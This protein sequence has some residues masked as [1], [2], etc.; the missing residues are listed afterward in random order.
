[1]DAHG[2]DLHSGQ[3][4]RRNRK[5]YLPTADRPHQPGT[6]EAVAHRDWAETG[7]C[8]LLTAAQ[9]ARLRLTPD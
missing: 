1:M 7:R 2:F 5:A 8:R 4:A 9:R 3:G 6:L